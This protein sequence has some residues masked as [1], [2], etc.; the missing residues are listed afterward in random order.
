MS[1]G[2]GAGYLLHVPPSAGPDSPI[3]VSIHGITR[4]AGEH[5]RRFSPLATE[6]GAIVV[7]PV[8]ELP[9]FRDYQRLGRPGRGERAD[10]ALRAILGE[11]RVRTGCR[12][13]KCH[14]FGY[15][16]GGQ[17][18]HRFAMAYP[19]EV[20]SYAIGAAGW[21][22]FPELQLEYPLGIRSAS[23]FPEVGFDPARFLRVPAAVFVGERDIHPGTALNKSEAVMEMQGPNR[24]ERGRRWIEAMTRAARQ[25]GL[26]TRFEFHSLRHS[27]HSFA[28]SDERGS[29]G[30]RLFEWFQLPA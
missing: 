16:G 25:R 18:A 19:E 15:S 20:E 22:T 8:F 23:D 10:L 12:A 29:L 11:V 30:K 4:N 28:K 2:V 3:L 14:L 27:C 9:R 7:A 17:F 13:R 1:V 26:D 6:N 24:F 5:V 21:Y